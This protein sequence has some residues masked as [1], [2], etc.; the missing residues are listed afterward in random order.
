MYAGRISTT[1]I[2]RSSRNEIWEKRREKR[3][4]ET[5]RQMRKPNIFD[6]RNFLC[7]SIISFLGLIDRWDC[8]TSWRDESIRKTRTRYIV[9]KPRWIESCVVPRTSR[10]NYAKGL[11]VIKHHSRWQRWNRT[12][13]GE[14]RGRKG[15]RWDEKKEMWWDDLFRNERKRRKEIDPV[16]RRKPFEL[17]VR[18]NRPTWK[19][20]WAKPWPRCARVTRDTPR[21]LTVFIAIHDETAWKKHLY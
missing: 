18:H 3:K 6:Y 2:Q 12:R 8:D 1:S 21:N 10:V 14:K 9:G 4:I 17:I 13:E 20:A 15:R 5:R 11:V 7:A 16:R 19:L